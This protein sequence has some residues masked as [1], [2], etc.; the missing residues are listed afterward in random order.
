MRGQALGRSYAVDDEIDEAELDDE[1]A[2]LD[3]QLALETEVQF[4]LTMTVYAGCR[5]L[6]SLYLS[7]YPHKS[8]IDS[9]DMRSRH[10]HYTSIAS[11]TKYA[12]FATTQLQPWIPVAM[13]CSQER[14]RKQIF[15]SCLCY[16]RGFLQTKTTETAKRR[17]Y[18]INR[19]HFYNVSRHFTLDLM[20]V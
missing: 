12:F 11:S 10:A 9:C 2:A 7:A 13:I 17:W 5:Q 3:E 16:P 4:A 1:L 20:S 14:I 15:P 19:S 6:L 8:F 18:N